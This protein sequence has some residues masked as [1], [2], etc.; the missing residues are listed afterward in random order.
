MQPLSKPTFF[1]SPAEFRD[2]LEKNH[3]QFTELW[4]GFYRKDSGRG[5][6]TYQEALDEALCFGWI[7]GLKKKVN[8]ISFTQRFTPRKKRSIWSAVNT[9][10]VGELGKLG[11]LMPPGL[12]AFAARDPERS[13]IYSFENRTRQLDGAYE[14]KFKA[15]RK[16][17][18]FFQSLPPGYRRT[19][20]WWVVREKGGDTLAAVATID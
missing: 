19:A 10:R 6:L 12:A 9:R 2:W 14:K 4:V 13:G 17:W 3:S 15:N 1:K 5:G 8:E 16:A 7:D 11:R 18:E 20:T